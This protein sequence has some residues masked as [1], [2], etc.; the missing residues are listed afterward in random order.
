MLNSDA[1]QSFISD[2]LGNDLFLYDPER[3]DRI[4]E[5]AENGCEGSTHAEII[6]DWRDFVS[7]CNLPE[8]CK[9]PL[10]KEINDVEQWHEKNGSLDDIIG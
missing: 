3:A 7:C 6:E 1:Y 10:L 5:Y 4:Y 8:K 2:R 9:E